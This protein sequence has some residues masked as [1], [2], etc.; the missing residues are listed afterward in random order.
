MMTSFV[1]SSAGIDVHKKM[2]MVT[3]MQERLDNS[4]YQETR[5]FGTLPKDLEDLASWLKS[6]VIQVAVMESTGVYW[7]SVYEAL[8]KVSVNTLVVNARHVK[9][10]PGRKTD[11]KDSE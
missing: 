8:E 7:K 5:K 6:E 2:V 4:T 9:Q 10:V 3:I 1:K 11:V